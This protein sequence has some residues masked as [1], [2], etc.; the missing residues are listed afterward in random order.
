MLSLK[1]EEP[2]KG[3]LALL[4]LGFR[5]FFLLAGVSSVALILAWIAAFNGLQSYSDYYGPNLWHGHE[6]LFGYLLAVIAGFLLTAV[7]N[8]T[9]QPMPKHGLLLC[10][11]VI[12]FLG[13]VAPF[14]S[15]ILPDVLIAIIDLCFMPAVGI[16]IGVPI[17][18][19]R[20]KRNYF[21]IPVFTV[22]VVANLL[23]H[24]DVLHVIPGAG[25]VGEK[26]ALGLVLV[27]TAVIGGRVIPFFTQAALKG[28]QLK[29][30]ALVNK[31]SIA[32]IVVFAVTYSVLAEGSLLLTAAAWFAAMINVARMRTWYTPQYWRVPLLWV[33]HMSY[34]WLVVGFILMGV[35]GLV[36]LP[37]KPSLHALTVGGLGGITLGMMAR[38]SL[39]HTGRPLKIVKLIVVAFVLLNVA[40]AVRVFGAILMPTLYIH[41]ITL[42]GVL[43]AAA[44]LLFVW[45]YTPILMR[46][47]VDG[48]SG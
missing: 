19:S 20:N 4:A 25:L 6:M 41:F 34:A 40:A 23:I 21:F 48:V 11:V 43:W 18:R 39:G 24:L 46:P 33:L 42:S 26:L 5:P 38:V 10:L 12:W 16:A 29:Q 30:S 2:P 32:S 1:I 14:F 44:F 7:G 9:G 15:A 47:R 28:V 37:G 22:F 36:V 13:R 8:W 31:L 35:E 27:V 17:I 45:V 3:Q